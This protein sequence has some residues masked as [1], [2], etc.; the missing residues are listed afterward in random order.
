MQPTTETFLFLSTW[1]FKPGGFSDASMLLLSQRSYSLPKKA[2]FPLWS[3]C[4]PCRVLCSCLLV[5]LARNI[6]FGFQRTLCRIPGS[7]WGID[8]TYHFKLSLWTLV[9]PPEGGMTC[10]NSQRASFQV[11]GLYRT[12]L[13]TLSISA[14][15]GEDQSWVGKA[16]LREKLVTQNHNTA[17][18]LSWEGNHGNMES[19]LSL[20]RSY[21]KKRRKERK[22]RGIGWEHSFIRKQVTAIPSL[23]PYPLNLLVGNFQEWGMPFCF[24]VANYQILNIKYVGFLAHKWI[25]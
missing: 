20:K 5:A 16:M 12:S 6:W 4:F 8:P 10:L 18:P 24:F 11:L 7:E 3:S 14:E 19:K 21:P 2:C 17:S 1:P 23:L 9:L 22:N 13:H 15:W 25:L